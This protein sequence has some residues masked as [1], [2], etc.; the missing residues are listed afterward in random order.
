[1][2]SVPVDRAKISDSLKPVQSTLASSSNSVQPVSGVYHSKEN[3]GTKEQCASRSE[4]LAELSNATLVYLACIVKHDG[5]QLSTKIDGVVEPANRKKDCDEIQN[6]LDQIFR[7]LSA[8]KKT[9]LDGRLRLIADEA[10]TTAVDV[11]MSALL[12][13]AHQLTHLASLTK[14]WLAT[15]DHVFRTVLETLQTKIKDS[16]NEES[17]VDDDCPMCDKK[18]S[19]K[20]NQT[21]PEAYLAKLDALISDLKEDSKPL[22]VVLSRLE[23]YDVQRATADFRSQKPVRHES[24]TIGWYFPRICF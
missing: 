11:V 21:T 7:S 5:K 23:K 9:L 17:R 19:E 10:T 20:D 2:T 16:Q 15:T 12:I 24:R 18:D 4:L 3:N 22:Q 8:W 6:Q 14:P 1:M 13:I